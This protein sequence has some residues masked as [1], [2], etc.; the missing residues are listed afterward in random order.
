[1]N[2]KIAQIRHLMIYP[3][4]EVYDVDKTLTKI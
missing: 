1:M 4:T 3:D 2:R